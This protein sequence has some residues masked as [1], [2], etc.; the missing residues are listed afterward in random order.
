MACG[1]NSQT[2]KSDV[3]RHP[4]SCQSVRVLVLIADVEQKINFG[5]FVIKSFCVL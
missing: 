1:T 3:K 4:R 5:C 2:S